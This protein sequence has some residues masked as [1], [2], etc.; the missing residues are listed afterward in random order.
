MINPNRWIIF[1]FFLVLCS[2]RLFGQTETKRIL[3]ES[4]KLERPIVINDPG[5]THRFCV[6][7]GPQMGDDSKPLFAETTG[8]RETFIAWSKGVISA[9]PDQ[10]PRYMVY[11]YADRPCDHI[12][13]G[14]SY[15]RDPA[16]QIGYFYLPGK[17]EPLYWLNSSTNLVFVEGNWFQSTAAWEKLIGPLIEKALLAEQNRVG[18]TNL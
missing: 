17:G 14:L 18:S 1:A 12:I 5:I 10:L 11:F 3:I 13:F 16:G 4:A 7:S 8:D 2:P 9:R 15:E 6:F